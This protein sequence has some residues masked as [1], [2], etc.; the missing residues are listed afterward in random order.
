MQINQMI[1][2]K[3][4]ILNPNE[5]NDNNDELIMND[6]FEQ[7]FNQHIIHELQELNEDFLK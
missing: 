6:D 7:Q 4:K 5:L 2:H 1:Y 3:H